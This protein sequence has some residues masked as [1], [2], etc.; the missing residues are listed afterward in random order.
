MHFKVL[1]KEC[2]D[3][4]HITLCS[5]SQK[6]KEKKEKKRKEKTIFFYENLSLK[7]IVYQCFF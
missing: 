5:N 1:K 3:K 2:G 7:I 6:K 4:Y